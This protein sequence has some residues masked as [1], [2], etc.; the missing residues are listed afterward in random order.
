[1]IWPAGATDADVLAELHATAFDSPW[2][3]PAIA[4][5]LDAEG[6]LA[7]TTEHGFILIRTVAGEAEVLTLAVAPAARRQG[8]G[9]RLIEAATGA[10]IQAGAEAIFLEVAADN[11]PAIGLYTVVGFHQVGR[12][13][14][15][16]RR[17]D[18]VTDALI[19]RK[20][21]TAPD[22]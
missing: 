5:L 15:Y 14:G 3:A 22:A 2:D 19:L 18:G 6:G 17:A 21:L 4:A 16:Y 9:R 13:K 20:T 1:M 10:A 8:L 11:T 12:R 7:L